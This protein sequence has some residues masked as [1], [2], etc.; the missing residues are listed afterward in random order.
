MKVLTNN[1]AVRREQ[2]FEVY[3]LGN[4]EVEIAVVPALGAKIISVKNL[5]TGREW[6]WHPPGELELFHNRPGDN[7]SRSPLVGV[8]ECLPTIDPCVWR[9][10]K[11]PD[12]GEVWSAEWSVDEEMWQ[13]GALKTSVRL[14]ISPFDFARTVE[15]DE[16]VVR[17]SYE[18]SNRSTAPEYFLWA[19]HPLLSLQP[20]DR[21]AL[22]AATRALLDGA[23]WVDA[24]DSV[25]P[26]GNCSKLLAGPLTEGFSG[27]HNAKTGEGFDF[28]WNAA[29]NNGLGLWLTRGGWHGHHHFAIEPTNAG[30]DALT[31][32]VGREWCGIVPGSGSTTWQVRFRIR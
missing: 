12:H 17:L 21:L 3:V 16:N 14:E 22:P 11:L 2:G 6:M 20:G 8:D 32:A 10:R 25:V 30:A 31:E 7:F 18:L 23:D 13:K 28:E 1:F 27:I 26:K 4:Q 24:I 29:E 9:G 15:L 5:R 19:M